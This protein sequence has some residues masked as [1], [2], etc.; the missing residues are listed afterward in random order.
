MN[1][2]EQ[3]FAALGDRTRLA[4]IERLALQ[5]ISLSELAE[6]FDMSQTAVTKHVRI[7]SDAGLV[8]VS[9][10]GRT[11][12]CRL[13]PEPMKAAE[14]WLETYQRFWAERFDDLAKFINE[15]QSK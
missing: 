5:E 7:L 8:K 13:R 6:P 12:Y 4:I 2:I 15:E 1:Q 3:T 14:E 10:R 9:K 11:R